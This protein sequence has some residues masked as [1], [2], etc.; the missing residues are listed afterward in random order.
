M[1]RARKISGLKPGKSV[2]FNA[3]KIVASR[4]R[5]FFALSPALAQPTH[6]TEL[7]DMRI[8]AKR[9]RYALELFADDLAPAAAA[10]I[11]T[12]KAFQEIV[13]EIHDN[14]VRADMLQHTIQLRAAA[15]GRAV[16]SFAA[17]VGSDEPI[18]TV[19]HHLADLVSAQ[20]SEQ[21]ALA[22]A[23]ARTVQARQAHYDHL[24]DQWAAW[25]A[26]GLREQLAALVTKPVAVLA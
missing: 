21:I 5:E 4:T 25:E 17:A 11:E 16:A 15:H 6:V 14:D 9:L 1:A 22:A 12:I 18:D 26:D 23:V 24:R 8:A 19:K 2:E 10:C 20:S 13:G 3:R 7:H